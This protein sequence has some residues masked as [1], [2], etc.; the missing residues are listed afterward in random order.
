MEGCPPFRAVPDERRGNV[1][2]QILFFKQNISI[3]FRYFILSSKADN[4]SS[5]IMPLKIHREGGQNHPER[6]DSKRC[7]MM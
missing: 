3:R 6:Q 1:S 5:G 4:V 2:M 7:R